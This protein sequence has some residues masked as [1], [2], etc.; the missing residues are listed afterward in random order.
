M[1]PLNRRHFLGLGAAG[2][3]LPKS[4]LAS[5]SE[6]RLFLMIF[7]RGGWDPTFVFTNQ[8]DNPYVYTPPYTELASNAAIWLGP[9]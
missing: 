9:A 7:V 5:G 2:L 6:D 3:C 8:V 4:V 1:F